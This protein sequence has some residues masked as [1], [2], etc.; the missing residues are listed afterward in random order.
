[1]NKS[2]TFLT[3]PLVLK[4][5]MEC[6]ETMYTRSLLN[7]GQLDYP[8]SNQT[9]KTQLNFNVPPTA[10]KYYFNKWINEMRQMHIRKKKQH[11]VALVVM[12]P[13]LSSSF[14]TSSGK[15]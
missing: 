10:K 13:P 9:Y 11:K 1:M 8:P 7:C 12:V 15:W 2:I 6:S 4:G 3:N 14:V 5:L